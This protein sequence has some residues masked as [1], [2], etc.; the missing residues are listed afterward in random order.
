M[1]EA[2]LTPAHPDTLEPLLDE[3]F[4]G[5]FDHPTAQRQPQRLVRRII[6]VIAV[7]VQIR[8]HL[9]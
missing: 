9:A 4:A 3:P 6:Q 7:L 1:V 5:T 8:I 2:R